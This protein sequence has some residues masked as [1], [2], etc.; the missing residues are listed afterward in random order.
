MVWW[1][2]GIG[3][4]LCIL[5]CSGWGWQWGGSICKVGELVRL[6]LR[7]IHL[8]QGTR[9]MTLMMAKVEEEEEE[10]ENDT[11][12]GREYTAGR[13]TCPGY[14]PHRSH[15]SCRNNR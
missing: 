4:V 15:V 10:E 1:G 2:I 9:H 14:S 7:V 8:S 5:D 6:S 12:T 3:S 11:V 13:G